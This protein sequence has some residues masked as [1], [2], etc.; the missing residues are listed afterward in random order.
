MKENIIYKACEDLAS[1]LMAGNGVSK[2][3]KTIQNVSEHSEIST[4]LYGYALEH[5]FS[6]RHR[7][8]NDE[9]IVRA[10]NYINYVHAI[11]PLLGK[12][13]WFDEMLRALLELTCPNIVLDNNIIQFF[14]DIEKG[15][16]KARRT[17]LNNAMYNT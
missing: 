7:G 10:I 4:K 3:E 5:A 9:L 12:Y 11:H 15:I 16:K 17:A 14:H 1:T 2:S 6:V 13:V 8:G